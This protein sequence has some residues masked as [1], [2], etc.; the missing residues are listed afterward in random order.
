[1]TNQPLPQL[2]TPQ[3][4]FAI[5]QAYLTQQVYNPLTFLL[6][7][8]SAFLYASATQTINSGT[9]TLVNLSGAS[10][11]P[12][13]GFNSSTHAW[14]VPVSGWYDV[15]GVV[16]FN[17]ATAGNRAAWVTTDLVGLGAITYTERWAQTGGGN[18]SAICGGILSL[19]Q[20]QSIGLV[21]YQSSGAG[22]GTVS[23]SN[24]AATLKL[25]FLHA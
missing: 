21:G 9:N 6:N 8:P 10:F 2:T 3:A 18:V 7:P 23:T 25:R 19:T 16:H 17:S 12:Y 20:N 14:V 15:E 11:D 5:S 1:M 13:G 4:G 22:L 24:G